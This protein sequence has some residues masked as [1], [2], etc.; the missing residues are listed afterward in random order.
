MVFFVL[1]LWNM[2]CGVWASQAGDPVVAQQQR[3]KMQV[4]IKMFF[5]MGVTWIAE[6][7]SFFLYW[8]VGEHKL[9]RKLFFFE[10]INS[11]QVR[12]NMGNGSLS[13]KHTK[14]IKSNSLKSNA[15]TIQI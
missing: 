1:F 14:E 4:V 10:L 7:I 15:Y 8:A 2:L 9:Y 13:I 11:L 6:L 5:V 3:Q 12:L